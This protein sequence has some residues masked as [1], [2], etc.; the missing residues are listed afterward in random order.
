MPAVDD[1]LC[2]GCGVPV[3][4]A[5]RRERCPHCGSPF[6]ERPLP[7]HGTIFGYGVCGLAW[8]LLTGWMLLS[9][10]AI[11][12]VHSHAGRLAML[13]LPA[14]GLLA[15]TQVGKRL[16]DEARG[17][18]ELVLL[19]LDA[20]AWAGMMVAMF[21]VQETQTLA[22]VIVAMFAAMWWVLSRGKR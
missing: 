9:A 3:P 19:S 13:A 6:G 22:G 15:A 21:G 8:G 17:R 18:Y 5:R 14:A 12:D 20:G 2:P 7:Y 1:D 11:D 16:T 4:L 10:G